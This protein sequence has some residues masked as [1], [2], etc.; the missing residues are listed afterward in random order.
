MRKLWRRTVAYALFTCLGCTAAQAQGHLLAANDLRCDAA[1]KPLAV[2]DAAPRLEWRL[3]AADGN[4]R[5]VGQSAYRVLVA[6]SRQVLN[7]DRG[8]MWDSGRV[9]SGDSFGV[10]YRGRPLEAEKAYFWKVMVWDER[11]NAAPWSMVESWTMAPTEWKAK[12][13]AQAGT[14]KDTAEM[15]LFR[16]Q[17]KV[18]RKLV[19]AMLYVSALGQGEVHLNGRKVGDAELSPS[20]TDYRKT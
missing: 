15:P 16:K 5:G 2:E 4:A 12:W 3:S 1:T 14:T 19:R 9:L 18:K 10:V 8:D 11:G 17:F 13:I 20:W 6:S 7:G